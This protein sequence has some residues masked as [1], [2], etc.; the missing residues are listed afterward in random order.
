[1]FILA[2][3]IN[4][5][6]QEKSA[7]SRIIYYHPAGKVVTV[8]T[9][10][11]CLA[12]LD[13]HLEVDGYGCFLVNYKADFPHIG[14]LYLSAPFHSNILGQCAWPDVDWYNKWRL[15]DHN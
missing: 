9:Y 2:K 7:G 1:V 12:H 14:A 5:R 10:T 11:N 3:F 6:R 4:R 13:L 8:G 15:A